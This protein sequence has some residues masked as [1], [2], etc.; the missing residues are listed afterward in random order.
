MPDKISF[1]FLF[2]SIGHENIRFICQIIYILQI[3][4]FIWY[5]ICCVV[6]YCGICSHSSI[7]TNR[8][9]IQKHKTQP[10]NW[11]QEKTIFYVSIYTVY[12][13]FT[14]L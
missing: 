9:W 3:N 14:T 1:Y 4:I 10:F 13:K 5:W 2:D 6:S 12:N 11:I 8:K 7:N